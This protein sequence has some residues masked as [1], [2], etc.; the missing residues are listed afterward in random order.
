[1]L[2]V[3]ATHLALAD[4]TRHK[5]VRALLEHPQLGRGPTILLGDMN[6]WRRCK[7]TRT[8]EKELVGETEIEWPRS[9]PAAR[10]MFALDRVYARGAT[11]E[12]VAA[13]ESEAARWASDHLPVVAKLRLGDD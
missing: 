10:P 13:H 3:V 8:L 7:A 6:A 4:R 12:K 11:V 2:E 5:Q 1:M 9:F